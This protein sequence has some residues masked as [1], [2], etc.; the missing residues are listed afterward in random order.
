M[1]FE[2]NGAGGKKAN[3]QD[4]SL[5]APPSGKFSDKAG[6]FTP[7]TSIVKVAICTA[8]GEIQR[9][10]GNIHTRHVLLCI[11]KFQFKRF[12]LKVGGFVRYMYVH[13]YPSILGCVLHLFAITYM[14]VQ[15]AFPVE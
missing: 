1:T 5:Y 15:L 9:Q 4:R 10:S 8:I 7:G 6:M 13:L 3:R 14:Y 11:Y 2:S 12:W